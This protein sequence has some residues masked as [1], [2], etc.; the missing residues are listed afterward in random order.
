MSKY[1]WVA[2]IESRPQCGSWLLSRG[3]LL[4]SFQ[5]T[6]H[7]SRSWNVAVDCVILSFSPGL[8]FSLVSCRPHK[9][10]AL[11]ARGWLSGPNGSD[12]SMCFNLFFLFLYARLLVCVV[13]LLIDCG[14][15]LDSV[16]LRVCV[17]CCFVRNK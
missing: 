2:G 14:I 16:C 11:H 15:V 10:H 1:S 3:S 17:I 9:G 4:A 13:F 8:A 6:L 5:K 12:F 7:P